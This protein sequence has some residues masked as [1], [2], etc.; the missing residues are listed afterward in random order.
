MRKILCL[1]LALI[2]CLSFTGCTKEKSPW[3]LIDEVSGPG[4]YI[5]QQTFYN[6]A[7]EKLLIKDFVYETQNG[8][9]LCV[10][11]KMTL[12]DSTKNNS[13]DN[14]NIEKICYATNMQILPEV[15]VD[16]DYVKISIVKY[17]ATD[18]WWEF[19]YELKIINKTNHIL[20][21]IIDDVSIMNIS[22]KPLFSID[23]I[24]A[25]NTVYFTM[26]WDKDTLKST[27]IPYIDNIKFTIKIFN[28]EIW[29]QPALAGNT[30]LIK[31]RG[32]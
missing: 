21:V 24:D 25:K 22:C 10:D 17:L 20:T 2:F 1:L 9:L 13:T 11:Q 31:N 26:A 16:N 18:N 3:V 7:N 32:N 30:I 23:H 14:R 4:N 6:E 12:I 15:L 27:Y 29:N 8:T 5:I 28:N 19:G